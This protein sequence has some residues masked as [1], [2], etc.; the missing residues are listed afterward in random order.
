MYTCIMLCNEII[1]YY[2][3]LFVI[4][5]DRNFGTIVRLKYF[6][7]DYVETRRFLLY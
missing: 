3:L 1:F 6:L 5:V 4:T 2:L 7:L